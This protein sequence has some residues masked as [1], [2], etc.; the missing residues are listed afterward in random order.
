MNKPGKIFL[1]RRHI[2]WPFM[3]FLFGAQ[4]AAQEMMVDHIIGIVGNNVILLSDI[5]NQYLQ[6]RVQGY[7][8][9]AERMKCQI[10]E[11]L[12]MQKLFLN[13]AQ[14][15]SVEV[16]EGE[17]EMELDRR[18]RVFINQAGSE[19]ALEAYYK[20]SIPEIKEN[21]REV[22][23]DQL[24]TQ[25]MQRQ[26]SEDIKVVPSEVRS[27]YRQ[28]AADSIP[29]IP[30]QY[31]VREIVRKPRLGEEAI[32][33]VKERLLELRSRVV[34][35]ENFATLAILYSEDPGSAMRGGELGY[36]GRGDLVKEFSSV[37]FSLKENQ[38]SQI[39]E[40]EFGYHIIQ[41]IG[42]RGDQVNVRHILMKPKASVEA[43]KS[44]TGFLDSLATRI[45][46]DSISF[47]NAAR[48]FS[49]NELTRM[50]GG[51][52]VNPE[53]GSTRF[54]K[55]EL[56]RSTEMA[57]RGLGR[58]EIS[59]PFETT[60]ENGRKIYKIVQLTDII[61]PHKANLQL[62]YALLQNMALNQ[63]K[64]SIIQDWVRSKQE[65]TYIRI[66]ER[67]RSC[68]FQIDGWL[69]STR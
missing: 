54:E 27:F 8:G 35:G 32:F 17:I 13:Q 52:L 29:E 47:E 67:Y 46:I 5:E 48:F 37:A 66:D 28:L 16:S 9:D 45:R 68:G 56:D 6:F 69:S 4:I 1:F 55:S 30:E 41:L 3:G 50:N 60:D 19:E 43:S 20:K 2:V 22:I 61:E 39:V 23:H 33:E 62:D 63:K 15:D 18:L 14:L 51:I 49:E 34:N 40:T 11:D 38:V 59:R 26:M 58:G 53:T 44:A 12:L 57:I 31:Q 24:L 65:K 36:M 42:R 64:N 7:T 21:F 10:F 25:R